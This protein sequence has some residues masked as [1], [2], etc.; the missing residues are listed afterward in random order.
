MSVEIDSPAEFSNENAF[1]SPIASKLYMHLF[2]GRDTDAED[3]NDW[4]FD[5]PYLGPLTRIHVA[6]MGV[7][8]L[9]F[10]AAADA[11]AFGFS[12]RSVL[13]SLS[14]GNCIAFAGKLYG[15]FT[16]MTYPEVL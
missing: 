5:G 15:D 9:E 4:G 14:E 6:Y 2:H 12:D 7:P 13:L 3:M 1:P 11:A 10:A 16:V 8:H